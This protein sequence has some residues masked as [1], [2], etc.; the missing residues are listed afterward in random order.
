MHLL[1]TLLL[2]TCHSLL[3]NIVMN[4]TIMGMDFNFFD[5]IKCYLGKE[6]RTEFG[7]EEKSHDGDFFRNGEFWLLL[8]FCFG[9]FCR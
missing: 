2:A 4:C 8:L 5:A 1:C 3:Y 9:F 7:R 6:E